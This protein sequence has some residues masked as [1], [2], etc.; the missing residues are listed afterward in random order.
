MHRQEESGEDLDSIGDRDDLLASSLSECGHWDG[1]FEISW[2]C[3]S[4]PCVEKQFRSVHKEAFYLL[5][6]RVL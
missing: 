2:H 6:H 4:V 5:P 3:F 1:I